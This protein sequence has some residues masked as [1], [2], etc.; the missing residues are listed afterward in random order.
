[1]ELRQASVE[2][3]ADNWKTDDVRYVLE[4]LTTDRMERVQRKAIEKLGTIANPHSRGV[5]NDVIKMS[6]AAILRRE[7]R[8]ALLKI[9]RA[10]R[11]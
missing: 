4:E 3:L 5:L 10:I 9:E 6:P 8:L 11:S 2:A 1:M 7:T